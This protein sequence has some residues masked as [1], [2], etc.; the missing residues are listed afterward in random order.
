MRRTYPKLAAKAKVHNAILQIGDGMSDCEI[1]VV[2]NYAE[3]AWGCFKG[4]GALPFT[5]QIT[6]YSLPDY[7]RRPGTVAGHAWFP[8][9]PFS[10]KRDNRRDEPAFGLELA[11]QSPFRLA[12]GS[13]V[14]EMACT[15]RAARMTRPAGM[16]PCRKR[17][18]FHR[19]C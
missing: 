4:I 3:G 1:T 6:Q 11:G 13:I 8:T 14:F 7:L 17:G 9:G 5:D 15:G 19:P 16:R 10:A 2:R 18:R 12:N